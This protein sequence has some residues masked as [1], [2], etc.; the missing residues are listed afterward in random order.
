MGIQYVYTNLKNYQ[1]TVEKNPT[2]CS[3]SAV[4]EMLRSQELVYD[5]YK[6]FFSQS[7]MN[8]RNKAFRHH[9]CVKV[10]PEENWWDGNHFQML[11]S[12]SNK[13]IQCN[14]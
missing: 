4:N 11:L 12:A 9:S 3:R 6:T 5:N 10:S 13:M 8:V 7:F 1:Y 14:F 2:C